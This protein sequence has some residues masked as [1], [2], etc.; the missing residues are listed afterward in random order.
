MTFLLTVNDTW[1]PE[2]YNK[3]CLQTVKT[4]PLQPNTSWNES[5]SIDVGGCDYGPLTFQINEEFDSEFS[6]LYS[7]G[8]KLCMELHT[9]LSIV[10]YAKAVPKLV[11]RM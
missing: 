9:G 1:Y 7:M 11:S 8:M 4:P 10:F 5:Q 3:T 2:E 6:F